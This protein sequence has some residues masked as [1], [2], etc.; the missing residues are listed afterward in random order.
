MDVS[1]CGWLWC[2]GVQSASGMGC[3]SVCICV[4]DLVSCLFLAP[5]SL[6]SI[7]EFIKGAFT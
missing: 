5:T 2:E 3:G 7:K 4:H 6:D 1:G